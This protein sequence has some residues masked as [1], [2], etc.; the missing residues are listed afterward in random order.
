MGVGFT[1]LLLIFR[2]RKRDDITG[3]FLPIKELVAGGDDNDILA[4]VDHVA[5]RL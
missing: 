2:Q 5:H 3:N 4:A 1:I